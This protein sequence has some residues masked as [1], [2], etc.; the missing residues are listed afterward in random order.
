YVPCVCMRSGTRWALLD[1]APSPT[2][3]C[4]AQCRG[5]QPS[6][7]CPRATWARS[8]SCINWTLHRFGTN[9]AGTCIA[10][11]SVQADAFDSHIVAV[12][13]LIDL[14]RS[15]DAARQ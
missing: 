7:A 13:R 3:S 8:K 2:T 6:R 5:P 4:I 11:D 15:V 10:H 9:L 1:T 12:E 14:P